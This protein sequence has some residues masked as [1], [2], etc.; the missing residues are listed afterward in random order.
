[1]CV[2]AQLRAAL[3]LVLTGCPRALCASLT[4]RLVQVCFGTTV[5]SKVSA[6]LKQRHQ[7]FRNL[8][9]RSLAQQWAV[10]ACSCSRVL[11]ALVLFLGGDR[12]R[13]PGHGRG[14]EG[15]FAAFNCRQCAD[16]L[17]GHGHRY[18]PAGVPGQE[19]SKRHCCSDSPCRSSGAGRSLLTVN[20]HADNTRNALPSQCHCHCML[21][22]AE[23][24]IGSHEAWQSA[25]V[26]GLCG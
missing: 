18:E 24:A 13:G 22:P 15:D 4:N 2:P 6:W 5:T 17:W 23:L 7:A 11:S 1:M 21:L 8:S 3:C 16:T 9:V 14:C 26:C 10:P 20:P 12:I 19:L 25:Q